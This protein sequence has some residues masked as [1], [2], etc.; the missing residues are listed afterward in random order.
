ML[1]VA[2]ALALVSLPCPGQPPPPAVR[3]PDLEGAPR[4]LFGLGLDPNRASAA[5]LEALPGVGPGR[6]AAIVRAREKGPFCRLEELLRVPGVGPV[7]LARARPWLHLEMPHGCATS[8]ARSSRDATAPG[9]V[10]LPRA[11][12]FPGREESH[13]HLGPRAQLRRRQPLEP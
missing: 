11:L 2:A 12:D 1:G 10:I 9:R 4:L 5:A 13:E 7:T 6:A 8:Q 3:G